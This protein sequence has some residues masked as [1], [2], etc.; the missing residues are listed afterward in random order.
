MDR[1]QG[2]LQA[3]NTA[4][5]SSS[6]SLSNL[7][8]HLLPPAR[9]LAAAL[10]DWWRRPSAQEEQQLQAAR[11]AAARSCAHLG[12]ANLSGNGGPA[13]GEGDG[14]KRCR[15]GGRAVCVWA[16]PGDVCECLCRHLIC[17]CDLPCHLND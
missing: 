17:R 9:Q 8:Q 10:L 15:W 16:S 1:L 5:P 7:Q 3:Y 13:A 2:A 12:C 14:S 6:P 4:A 11:A